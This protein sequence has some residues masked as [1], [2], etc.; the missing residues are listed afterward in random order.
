VFSILQ[1]LNL[2]LESLE[3]ALDLVEEILDLGLI[4]VLVAVLA[5]LVLIPPSPVVLGV[6]FGVLWLGLRGRSGSRLRV[7]FRVVG[8]WLGMLGLGLRSGSWVGRLRG[9]VRWLGGRSGGRGSRGRGR[10][11]DR[12]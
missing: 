6:I 10:D 12:G 7:V 9:W 8:L 11:G 2:P 3:L 1:L 5:V 4:T